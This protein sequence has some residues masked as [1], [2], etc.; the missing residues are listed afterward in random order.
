MDLMEEFFQESN[1]KPRSSSGNRKYYMH[2]NR[3]STSMNKKRVN[4][5]KKEDNETLDAPS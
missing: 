1:N 3:S 4:V 5:E 2:T